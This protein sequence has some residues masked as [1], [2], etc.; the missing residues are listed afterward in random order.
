MGNKRKYQICTRCIMDTSD[1]DITFDAEGVCNHCKKFDWIR[2]NLWF[3]NEEGSKRLE[4]IIDEIKAKGKG[5]PYD[6]IMGLS[7]GVD[8]SYLAIKAVEFGLRPLVVHVDAGWNSELAISNIELLV[9]KLGLDL[10]T[11]V[12]DWAEMRDLHI[13]YFKSGVANQDVP[14]DHAFIARLLREAKENGI[15]YVLNGSNYATESILPQ[16]WGYSAKDLENLEAIH[17]RFGSGKLKTYPKVSFWEWYFYYPRVFGIKYVRPLNYMHYN[18]DE[19]KKILME[20]Y[21]WRDYGGKHYESRFTKFFQGYYL[22][23]RFGYDKRRAHLASLIV[24]GQMSREDALKEMETQPYP[25]EDLAE[26]IL[27]IRKKLGF[28]EKEFQEIM[29]APRRLATEY[30]SEAGKIEVLRK[31]KKLISGN[32]QPTS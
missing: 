16:A 24:S 15:K 30:P 7:G 2:E 17:A 1:P 23:K 32:T 10:H 14:Q 5:K 22:V 25:L 3:P 28:S 11:H 27:F 6:C 31:I 12:V 9:R 8:S 18:K 13:A 21:G 29:D 4:L 20:D 19:A 26:D